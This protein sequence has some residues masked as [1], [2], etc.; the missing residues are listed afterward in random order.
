MH[1]KNV[2][3]KDTRSANKNGF[4]TCEANNFNV[5]N[6]TGNHECYCVRE[7]IAD[8]LP[9]AEHCADDQGMEFCSCYGTVYYGRAED[10][11]TNKSLSFAQMTKHGWTSVISNGDLLCD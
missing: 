3:I 9:K 8:P 1:E 10:P 5:T 7:K 2:T 4:L 11:E 6:S